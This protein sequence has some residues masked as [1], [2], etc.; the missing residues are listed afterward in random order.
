MKLEKITIKNFRRIGEAEITL[1]S[2]SFII[3]PNNCGKTSVI[4]AID[5]LLSLKSEKVTEADFRQLK[6]GTKEDT[7][8]LTGVF[9]NFSEETSQSRGFRGRIID[10]KFTYK[11]AIS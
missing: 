4:D 10:G 6:D 5:A 2:S 1:A 8:E 9:S 11:K 3:G 7:L